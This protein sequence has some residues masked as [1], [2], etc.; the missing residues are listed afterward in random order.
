MTHRTSANALSACGFAFAYSPGGDDA[1]ALASRRGLPQSKQP[2]SV[3]P[4]P[5]PFA[6][7]GC[8]H[9]QQTTANPTTAIA[10]RSPSVITLSSRGRPTGLRPSGTTIRR[11]FGT[12][13]GALRRPLWTN[14]NAMPACA[15][16][17]ANIRTAAKGEGRT[18]TPKE[19]RALAGEWYGWFVDS[20]L[21]IG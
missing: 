4:S 11:A 15:T 1:T 9:R 5:I 7:V 17:C 20:C 18:L 10:S 19:A 12:G 3:P 21:D 2:R 14:G 8:S 13:L 6:A 16:M